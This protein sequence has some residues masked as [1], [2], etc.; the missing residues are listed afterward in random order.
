MK[1][2][3]KGLAHEDPYDHI[4]NFVDVCGPFLFKNITQ[5]AVQLWLFPFP[6]I[7]EATKWLANLPRELITSWQEL[8]EAF[9]IRFFPPSKMMAFRDNIQGFKRLDGEPIHET[10]LRFQKLLRQCPAHG[11]PN[12]MLLQ[13]FYWSLNSV[14]KGVVDQLVRRGIMQQPFEIMSTLFDGMTKINRAWYTREDQVSPLT[15]KMTKEQIEKDQEWDENMAKIMTQIDLLSKHVMG[16]GSKVD[17]VL[18]EMKEDVSTLNQKVTFHSV[19]IKQLET[20]MGQILS[21]LNPRQKGNL[22]SDTLVNPK[23][24]P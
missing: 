13:H 15:F 8:T 5:E 19:S 4:R 12:N 11:L 21:H 16:S 18:K 2:L 14:N 24:E 1:G 17:K 22:P 6:L 20:Q 10:W 9:Y 3:F 23:N 7:G